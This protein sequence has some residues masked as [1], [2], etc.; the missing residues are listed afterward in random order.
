MKIN[1]YLI[2]F[3]FAICINQALAIELISGD[4]TVS[5]CPRSTQLFIDVVKND[6]SMVR[7]YTVNVAGEAF[8]WATAMPISFTLN[9]GESKAIYTYVTPYSGTLPKQYSL[10]VKVSTDDSSKTVSHLVNV[11]DCHILTTSGILEKEVCEGD[12]ATF[13]FVIQNLGE[14]QEIYNIYPEG[15]ISDKVKVSE[16]LIKLNP[17]E[18]KTIYAYAQSEMGDSGNYDFSITADSQVS[19]AISTTKATLNVKPCYDYNVLTETDYAELCE[20]TKTTIPIK[21]DNKGSVAN[22]YDISINGPEW[23]SLSRSKLNINPG[24]SDISEIVLNPD[25]DVEGG[26]DIEVQVDPEKG[27]LNAKQ[28][29]KANIRKCNSLFVDIPTDKDIMCNSISNNYNIM[30]KNTGEVTKQIVL[31][32]HGPEW[33]SVDDLNQFTLEPGMEKYVTLNVNPDYNTVPG[34]YDISVKAIALDNS[35]TTSEDELTITT[36]SKEDCYKPRIILDKDSIDVYYDGSATIPVVVENTGAYETTYELDVSDTASSFVQLNPSV[37]DVKPGDSAVTHIYIAP[38]AEVNEGKYL[39]TISARLKDSTILASSDLNVKVTN[40]NNNEVYTSE[41]KPSLWQRI[42]GFFVDLFTFGKEETSQESNETIEESSTLDEITSANVFENISSEQTQEEIVEEPVEEVVEPIEETQE[43]VVE[44]PTADEVG[45]EPVVEEQIE[46]TTE[47]QT[48]NAETE[49]VCKE[50]GIDSLDLVSKLNKQLSE[51]ESYDFWINGETHSILLDTIDENS[52]L[53]T[54]SSDPQQVLINVG[55]TKQIDINNDGEFD[56]K[57]TLNNIENGVGDYTIT[58]IEKEEDSTFIKI[59]KKVKEY[60]NYI[61]VAVLIL[62]LII[63]L[64]KTKFHKKVVDFFEEEVEE[65][66]K[67]ENQEETKEQ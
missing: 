3:I 50:D 26:F 15:Q 46:N 51:E 44:E 39:A 63:I 40:I 2:F 52:T 17:G 16:E 1:K 5:V 37:L 59:L 10:D 18:S 30:V 34:D 32:I 45:Q 13:D 9:P 25:Y 53:I 42:K 54:I 23:A 36:V 61:I 65:E 57:V 66:I 27:N 21:I 11:K 12:S 28:N 38:N 48:S 33:I 64:A 41:G 4:N 43:E 24:S 29:F 31:E 55:E 47:E 22:S 56:I 7:E 58:K 62:L 14:Y 35:G 60:E 19:D 67:E 8:S 20:A 6:E 49:I